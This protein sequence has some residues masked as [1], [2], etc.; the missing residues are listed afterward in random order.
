[1]K[2]K[3]STLNVLAFVCLMIIGFQ[4]KAQVIYQYGFENECGNGCTFASPWTGTPDVIATGLTN[5]QWA[6]N[7]SGFI[8]YDGS[9]GNSSCQSLAISG[10]NEPASTT[11]TLSFNVTSGYA[12]A[13]TGMS[14]WRR[15]SAT[16]PTTA[17]I[18][19]NGTSAFSN[20][21]LPTTGANTGTLTPT[22]SFTNL[23]G[24]F[25]LVMTLTGATNT[26]GTFRLDDFILDGTVT[27]IAT[28]PTVYN[29]T[30][31]G[32]TCANSNGAAIGISNSQTGVSY[33]VILNGTNVGTPVSGTGSALN[34][35]NFLTAGTYTVL[36]TNTTSQDTASMS[37]SAVVVV[38]P[39][40][41]TNVSQTICAGQ[42]Y[43]G[44]NATGVY[45]DTLLSINGCDSIVTLNLTSLAPVTS[46][47]SKSICTGQSYQGHNATGIYTDTLLSVNGCDSI[48]TLTLMVQS[49]FTTSVTQT[50]CNGQ[51][52]GGHT[53]TGVYV[54][55]LTSS[56]GCDSI[57]TLNLTVQSAVSNS[58]SQTICSGQ[59]YNGHNA[60]GTYVDTLIAS[61]GC[62]SIVTLHLT[63]SGTILTT[64]L[65]QTICS[66]SA[67]D[68]HNATGVYTDTL[69][70]VTGCDSI[71]T[72]TLT[73]LP[74][75]GV[76]INQTI[77]AGDTFMGHTTAGA[78]VDTFTA[79]NGCDSIVYL[80]LTVSTGSQVTLTLG[81]DT[82]CSNADTIILTGGSPAGGVYSGTGVSNGVFYPYYAPYGVDTIY[83]TFGS[84]G[85]T[86]TD[87]A[88]AYELTAPHVTLYLTFDT[89]CGNADTIILSG[90]SPAGGTYSGTGVSNGVFNPYYAP[91]G[92]DTIYYTYADPNGCSKT[93]YEYAYEL[94]PPYVSLQLPIDTFCSDGG[95]VTLTGGTPLGGVYSGNSVTSGQ[96]NPSAAYLGQDTIYYA[97]TDSNGC[98]RTWHEYA[99]VQVCTGINVPSTAFYTVYPIPTSDKLIIE[100][101]ALTDNNAIVLYDMMG[102]GVPL[103]GMQNGLSSNITELNLQGL[104]T[105][106]YLLAILADHTMVFSQK[107]IKE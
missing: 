103:P 50:I 87:S 64:N 73:V 100:S 19:I 82:I 69:T 24:T 47:V 91:Y 61:G 75:A 81:F 20:V 54:D 53:S 8:S 52:Y 34:L 25:N 57:R 65:Q 2:S 37:G 68:G 72:L 6:T 94:T 32:S 59:S 89:I 83:Y 70:A 102:R 95:A 74:G 104:P 7:Y 49:T 48:V 15:V 55:T 71:V 98:S 30:G 28:T 27:T 66:G 4:T 45:V 67:Y 42:S 85:C 105:G 39:V 13:I 5:S 23:T 99:Q 76:S 21:A 14:F 80:Q 62:D 12:L 11:Y 31:G 36:A 60:T 1:M 56:G 106:V 107:V 18:T 38:K 84:T 101:S 92:T 33:Q 79:S 17:A 88:Y 46:S 97:Y 86:G 51:S 96:F 44:H 22:A 3:F 29:V 35:G 77:C 40:V 93:H 78:Y 10:N 41:S 9:C 63:V 43:L 16:G 58:I 90:G 26:G